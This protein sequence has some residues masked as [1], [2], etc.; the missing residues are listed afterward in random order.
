MVVAGVALENLT[1]TQLTVFRRD[2]LGFVFQAFNLLPMLTAEQNIW[3]PLEL[4]GR[5]RR[6][7]GRGA[8][9]DGDRGRSG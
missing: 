6:R 8:V 4:A 7:P 9:P 5:A 3:L 2:Q 1:D